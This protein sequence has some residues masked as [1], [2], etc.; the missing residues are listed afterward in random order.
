MHDSVLLCV[1]CL[2]CTRCALASVRLTMQ[3]IQRVHVVGPRVIALDALCMQD[4]S[5][6]VH[7]PKMQISTPQGL[8]LYTSLQA[9]LYSLRRCDAAGLLAA[10]ELVASTASC[11]VVAQPCQLHG[12]Q[13]A[14]AVSSAAHEQP[15]ALQPDICASA[16]VHRSAGA[17]SPESRLCCRAVV[18]AQHVKLMSINSIQL[19]GSMCSHGICNIYR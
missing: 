12:G 5:T 8:L 6:M 14:V 13:A 9:V 10:S 4:T 17:S 2:P 1:A 19:D 16:R 11:A 18:P 7:S 15:G 3:T